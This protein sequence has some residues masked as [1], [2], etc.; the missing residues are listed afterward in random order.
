MLRPAVA[1]DDVTRPHTGGVAFAAQLD[2]H[3]V[4]G[5]RAR[6]HR[7]VPPHLDVLE[8]LQTAQQFGVDQRLH[9]A[10]ALGPAETRIGRGHFGKYPAL[11][12]EETQNLVGYGVRQDPVDQTDRLEGAQR[13]VV[14]SDPARVVDERVPLLDHQRANTL[15]AKDVGYGQSD[16]A[17]ADD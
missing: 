13:L 10:I 9:E 7:A 8:S 1:A 6:G 5:L 16:R 15:Q 3:R 4:G 14:Q 2:G 11:G 12:V 17:G